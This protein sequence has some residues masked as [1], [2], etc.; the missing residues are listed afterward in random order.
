MS[1]QADG[2]GGAADG[3][4]AGSDSPP[5]PLTPREVALLGPYA[6]LHDINVQFNHSLTNSSPAQV[7][8]STIYLVDHH[9]QLVQ[10]NAPKAR[11][12]FNRIALSMGAWEQDQVAE[13]ASQ[14]LACEG[15]LKRANLDT[16]ER[17][18][19]VVG[20]MGSTLR[21][22]SGAAS[23]APSLRPDYRAL[24]VASPEAMLPDIRDDDM[25]P[26][27]DLPAWDAEGDG[28]DAPMASKPPAGGVS[29]TKRACA[30]SK[31]PVELSL[32]LVGRRVKCKLSVHVAPRKCFLCGRKQLI[33]FRPGACICTGS[34][35]CRRAAFNAKSP[36]V[37]ASIASQLLGRP[38][39]ITEPKLD[40]LRQSQ[41]FRSIIDFHVP[42]S[43]VKSIMASMMS[44]AP[45]ELESPGEGVDGASP[46]PPHDADGSLLLS[47]LQALLASRREWLA[48]DEYHDAVTHRSTLKQAVAQVQLAE[49]V[50]DMQPTG[51]K[52]K[53]CPKCDFVDPT[54]RHQIDSRQCKRYLREKEPA[55]VEAEVHG[56]EGD[57][58][59]SKLCGLCGRWVGSNCA[60]KC[61]QRGSKRC[62]EKFIETLK[63][64]NT[65]S[66]PAE[67]S[68][69]LQGK[70][71]VV[72]EE[73]SLS[74]EERRYPLLL[75]GPPG[76]G[77]S[78][79]TRRLAAILRHGFGEKGKVALL[80]ATGL[81][82]ESIGGDTIH[83]WAGIGL[84]K[85]LDVS[86]LLKSMSTLGRSNLSSVQVIIFDDASL[87]S[88]QLFDAL[89][90][91]ARDI[92]SKKE[93]FFGGI[94]IV[95]QFDLQQLPPVS[96]GEEGTESYRAPL[97]KSKWWEHLKE[98]AD[99]GLGT[100]IHLTQ[101][102]RFGGDE[103][104]MGLLLALRSK[105]GLQKEQQDLLTS[106]ELSMK[107]KLKDRDHTILCPRLVQVQ[108]Y[109]E[110][111]LKELP[112][113]VES[114][115]WMCLSRPGSKDGRKD[116]ERMSIHYAP[117]LCLKVGTT[118]MHLLK[119]PR[120]GLVNGTMGKVE[121][122][123]VPQR[124]S[125]YPRHPRCAH[126]HTHTPTTCATPSH[127][128]PA[129]TCH[130]H[131][132]PARPCVPC[133]TE[134]YL[135]LLTA[136]DGAA[137]LLESTCRSWIQSSPRCYFAKTFHSTSILPLPSS[138]CRSS[139]RRHSPFT[140]P[141]AQ[142]CLQFWWTAATKG[143]LRLPSSMLLSRASLHSKTF[144]SVD[145]ARPRLT[146]TCRCIS[147]THA[148]G[149][150]RVQCLRSL[151]RLSGDQLQGGQG[152]RLA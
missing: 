102:H 6:E 133:H 44:A 11:T 22:I 23:P 76:A 138:G 13:V 73:L 4:A 143:C 54:G 69:P 78:Y 50:A 40:H 105:K 88:A 123:E 108:Q 52:V 85:D 119:N 89:E 26:A 120:H 65:T 136:C 32:R 48:S 28:G 111:A 35:A 99:S 27:R 130:A 41:S 145:G 39:H 147:D 101:Q 93:L 139:R 107:D 113:D 47:A 42:S 142:P 66:L 104:L 33:A 60:K 24:G 45:V 141:W 31:A 36:S 124:P 95:L 21:S 57:G 53:V 68:E 92:R 20:F 63:E 83:A 17:L 87:V 94:F 131:H 9:I 75:F 5:P 43:A 12:I 151:P 2:S 125:P 110:L 58:D 115:P 129:P 67:V 79:A 72:C 97:Y 80:S 121:G 127:P 74:S 34:A 150:N 84:A 90:A 146:Y 7:L 18:R 135:L 106:S 56:A 29:G 117:P 3:A 64:A 30:G 19:G 55:K 134:L 82:A 62:Y 122:W 49:G 109:N 59:P 98:W 132:P 46:P 100:A 128:L 70:W 77:K 8:A 126:S 10:G 149:F 116:R 51:T 137:A 152:R 15:A 81:L 61:Q 96:E 91:V 38:V 1:T 16:T 114:F 86:A 148:F 14:V 103:R 25:S 71:D 37:Q 112:G 144:R 140:R 118:V